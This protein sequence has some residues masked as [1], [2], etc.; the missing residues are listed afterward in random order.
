MTRWEG[1]ILPGE[2]V[3]K[4]TG[5]RL[6]VAVP[7][8]DEWGDKPA[9]LAGKTLSFV[10]TNGDKAQQTQLTV[11][12]AP[13]RRGAECASGNSQNV[14]LCTAGRSDPEP[15]ALRIAG[16]GMKLSSVLQAG[17]DTRKIRLRFLAT[18][19]GILTS[20][21]LLATMVTVLKLTGA[22]LAGAS[23]SRTRGLLG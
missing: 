7:V 20:F 13:R 15:D 2:P 3:I 1:D 19:A 18:S 8:T 5:N 23:S 6:Q 12:A 9:T 17:T 4:H 22:S 14:G 11:G 16:N 10:V 21:M